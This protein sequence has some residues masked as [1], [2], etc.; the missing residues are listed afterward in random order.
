MRHYSLKSQILFILSL[1]VIAVLCITFWG[2]T[3]IENEQSLLINDI[4]QRSYLHTQTHKLRSALW[5]ANNTI[6][7]YS[8]E[9]V[10][11]PTYITD[12]NA[13]VHEALNISSKFKT[14]EWLISKEA[15][16]L[17]ESID[18]TIF[19]LDRFDENIKTKND[20]IQLK[21]YYEKNVK[22]AIE[23]TWISLNQLDFALE[24][25][26][27]NNVESFENTTKWLNYS[28]SALS[29]SA[30]I[31]IVIFYI[32]LEKIIFKPVKI[33]TH[34]LQKGAKGEKVSD[35]PLDRYREIASLNNA[36]NDMKTQVE[37]RQSEL[38]HQ[39][40]HD[41]LTGLPNRAHLTKIIK[42]SIAESKNSN[43]TP[44]LF[45]LDLNRFKEIN[46]T[47]GHHIGDILLQD[48][49]CRLS[50]LIGEKDV[51]ARLG[52]DE[53]GI[54]FNS[55]DREVIENI[56]EQIIIILNRPFLINAHQLHIS[57][58]L[59]IATYPDL[60]K[61]EIEM[62]RYA[63]VAMYVAKK[64]HAGYAFYSPKED[65]NS[66]DRLSL[67]SE[68]KDAINNN[69]LELY[70][71]PKYSLAQSRTIEVEAL[72]RWFHP[73]RGFIPPDLV[74][75]VAEESGLIHPL[76]EWV[77]QSALAQVE[78]WNQ[79]GLSIDVAVNLS[80]FN[81]QNPHLITMIK[82]MLDMK[83]ISP[84]QL[85]LE[86]TESAMMEN[87]ELAKSVLSGLHNMG[88]KIA[89]DDFGTGYSSLAYLKNLPVNELKI[90]RSFIMN[91]DSDKSDRAIV[92]STI[93]LA[94]NLGLSVVAEGVE[95]QEGW[96]IL[97]EMGCDLI[98][99]YFLSKPLPA[100]EFEQWFNNVPS[101][102]ASSS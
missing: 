22:P 90:D 33:L 91:I 69:K 94:H 35:L 87:P 8:T 67:V 93:D 57:A 43:N 53:F 37:Q 12:I 96:N 40:M 64:N 27:K 51:V 86:V 102:M 46:D 73:E 15:N 1:T 24:N 85:I 32:Y 74:I 72:L 54:L 2:N 97:A 61:D 78:N 95:T 89:I 3:K 100:K 13:A 19:N 30:I 56:A 36:F 10:I 50:N 80:V 16:G 34:A 11:Y 68:L 31:L 7:N 39:A 49:A 17:L 75:E 52:G 26:E 23:I 66:L 77:L 21:N 101:K 41:S 82:F 63:D 9:S 88:L 18:E 6:I 92:K 99:G 45:L 62:M 70:F 5:R 76:T 71:Q 83:S 59:G 47:I 38:L 48:A 4:Q 42:G 60:A 28:I 79:S 58:S 65:Q 98:Q 29:I 25:S 55:V 14:T 44:A 81:L 20:S 84:D